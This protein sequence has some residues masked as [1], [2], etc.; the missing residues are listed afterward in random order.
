[1]TVC[2]ASILTKDWAE[3]WLY[4]WIGSDGCVILESQRRSSNAVKSENLRMH[5]EPSQRCREKF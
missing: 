2:G 4:L 5:K 1:M 3:I